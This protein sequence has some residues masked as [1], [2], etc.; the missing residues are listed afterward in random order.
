MSLIDILAIPAFLASSEAVYLGAKEIDSSLLGM[1]SLI[2]EIAIILNSMVIHQEI[3]GLSSLLGSILILYTL[4][5]GVTGLI[6]LTKEK[7]GLK[8]QTPTEKNYIFLL[9]IV[10]LIILLTGY[11]NFF[12]SVTLVFLFVSYL[13]IKRSVIK[14][15]KVKTLLLLVNGTIVLWILSGPIV[16]DILAV[17]SFVGVNPVIIATVTLPIIS[18]YQEFIIAI[19][20]AYRKRANDAFAALMSE[21]I[22]ASTLLLAMIGV[23]SPLRLYSLS[24]LFIAVAIGGILAYYSMNNRIT[25]KTSMVFILMYC[26][27]MVLIR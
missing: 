8:S 20:M 23:L 5:F 22:Q 14:V 6:Y 18:N 25:L 11:M 7:K 19:R 1:A 12:W 9:S 16:K 15:P 21:N 2:P 27:T 13:W 24:P 26:I 3:V 4:A 17:S 10:M